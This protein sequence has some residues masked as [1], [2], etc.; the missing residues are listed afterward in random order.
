MAAGRRGRPVARAA[1]GITAPDA[2]ER[3]AAMGGDVVASS[4]ADFAA[5]MRADHAKWA[6]VIKA[7]GLKAEPEK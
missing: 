6:R 1:V 5:F 7:A 3:L 4:V 2:R